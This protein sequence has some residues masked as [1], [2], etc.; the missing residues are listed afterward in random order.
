MSNGMDTGIKEVI[1]EKAEKIATNV[2]FNIRGLIKLLEKN[3][4]SLS[5]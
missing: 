4:I 5:I 3:L 2:E 1:I